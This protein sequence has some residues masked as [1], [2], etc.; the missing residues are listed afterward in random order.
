MWYVIQ[1]ATGQ[2]N[3]LK[4][5]IQKVIPKE[6]YRECFY[7]TRE[8]AEK[9]NDKWN[10]YHA[11]LFP[12]YLFIDTDMPEKV[13]YVLKSIP[14]LTKLLKNEGKDFLPVSEDEKRFLE[15]IQSEGH[16]VKRSL[17][18]LNDE[19]K[20]ISA[21]GAVGKYFHYIV[22]QK[23][24]K[25]YVIIRQNFLGKER[26][27]LLGIKLDDDRENTILQKRANDK[28]RNEENVE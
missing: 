3:I 24:R 18:N 21:Q 19:R 8:Y 10:V 1:T 22:K 6:Y 15:N 16:L 28:K 7:F 27:I 9:E 20:I 12:G 23:L 5:M 13:Y 4:D 14:K 26:T 2:E 17:V 11:V 25:R